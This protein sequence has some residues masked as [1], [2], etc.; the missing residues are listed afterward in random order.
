MNYITL[1][2]FWT[3]YILSKQKLRLNPIC[4]ILAMHFIGYIQL[5]G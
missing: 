1:A 5:N 4:I 2:L 3:L